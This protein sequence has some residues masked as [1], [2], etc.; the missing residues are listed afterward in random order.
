MALQQAGVRLEAEGAQTFDRDIERAQN[1]INDFGRTAATAGAGGLERMSVATVALGTAL[2][3]LAAQAVNA[4]TRGLMDFV[5]TGV[6]YNRTLENAQAQLLAFT[7]SQEAANEALAIAERRASR[8]PF[9]FE[10][11][12]RTLGSI[13]A[14]QKANG[15]DLETYLD[16]VERLAASNP[17]Q[18]FEGAAFALREA[19]S[20]DFLS[21]QD[22]FNIPRSVIADLKEA[23]FSAET[24]SAAM[25]D[26]GFSTELVSNLATTFDGRLS[27]LK[28]T[29]TVAAG[30]FTQPIF[31]SLSEGIFGLQGTLDQ[32]MPA[33]QAELARAGQY[34]ADTLTSFRE[35]WEGNWVDDD[36]IQPLHRVAGTLGIN[37]RSAVDGMIEAW[38][39]LMSL[40]EG[41]QAAWDNMVLNWQTMNMEGTA[42]NDVMQS[43]QGLWDALVSFAGELN[44][45]MGGVNLEVDL[46]AGHASILNGILEHTKKVLDILTISVNMA[47]VVLQIFRQ[48]LDWVIEG[49]IK[50]RDLMVAGLPSISLSLPSIGNALPGGTL[51][52]PPGVVPAPV[53][54]GKGI[55]GPPRVQ[56]SV[57]VNVNVP[58]GMPPAVA[59]QIVSDGVT[60]AMRA[61]GLA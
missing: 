23:G 59:T 38:G 14:I 34:V 41:G 30:A 44:K 32:N 4:A 25:N 12:A 42:W 35:G 2:G 6:D 56:T 3:Q 13:A 17:E 55:G 9:A 16:L 26:L 39:G 8:T 5:G 15:G 49:W 47:S 31:E 51:G 29:F 43:G 40:V 24:L 45:A 54:T 20:G 21:L 33:I 10:D 58:A 19:F 60:Q 61:Q 27:T 18:G 53:Q 22:R 57:S 11:Y 7:G 1:A 46:A 36:I 37:V 48:G 28:D 50:L 52:L